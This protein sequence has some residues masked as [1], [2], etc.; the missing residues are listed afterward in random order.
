MVAAW[1]AAITATA[2]AS[3]SSASRDRAVVFQVLAIHRNKN[4]S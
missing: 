3:R 1:W 4:F 2:I